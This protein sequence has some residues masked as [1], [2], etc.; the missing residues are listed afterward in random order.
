MRFL[1]GLVM[2]MFATTTMAVTYEIRGV[3]DE[4]K[5]ELVAQLMIEARA[6]TAPAQIDL[7][8]DSPGG[9]VE[10]GKEIISMMKVLQFRGT[11][12]VCTLDGE[13]AASMAAVSYTQCDV[14]R[15]VS[16]SMI[17]FHSI[18][19]VLPG[20]FCVSVNIPYLTAV[21]ADLQQ[22]QNKLEF[23]IKQTFKAPD[24]I[25]RFLSD[26]EVFF[27]PASANTFSPGFVTEIVAPKDPKTKQSNV[28]TLLDQVRGVNV[29]N[30]VSNP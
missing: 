22:E 12:I 13:M 28:D 29:L 5:R 6:K 4:S 7:L 18:L 27:S 21:L 24:R 14:R 17:L 3:I 19:T 1:L 2:L 26:K 30:A 8:I 9:Y 10:V 15:A 16:T 20:L 23:M 25:F 11:K